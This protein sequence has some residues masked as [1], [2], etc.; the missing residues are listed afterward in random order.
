TTVGFAILSVLHARKKRPEPVMKL[1]EAPILGG[2]VLVQTFDIIDI[3]TALGVFFQVL[4]LLDGSVQLGEDAPVVNQQ[5]VSLFLVHPVNPG[6]G[7]Y[8]IVAIERLIDIQ[9]CI[10][11]FIKASE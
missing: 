5:A 10:T 8:K 1:W 7:L 3:E 2:H 11:R 4:I 9:H 6:N